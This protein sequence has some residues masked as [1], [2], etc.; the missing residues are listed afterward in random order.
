MYIRIVYDYCKASKQSAAFIFADIT[1]ALAVLIRPIIFDD[2]DNDEEWLRK[3]IINGFSLE[4]IDFIY[5]SICAHSWLEAEGKTASEYFCFSMV[6]SFY[7][8][9]WFSQQS[10]P[11]V[12]N[13]S[14]GCMEGMPL[15]DIMYAITFFR[16]L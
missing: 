15:A 3:L 5:G 10:L 12:V 1:T 7:K 16:V 6:S 8:H 9:T 2:V 13:T 11:G 4:E 14:L